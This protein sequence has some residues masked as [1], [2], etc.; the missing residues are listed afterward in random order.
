MRDLNIKTKNKNKCMRVQVIIQWTITTL[1]WQVVFSRRCITKM[2]VV[3]L[4]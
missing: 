3:D 2:F 1:K 4:L